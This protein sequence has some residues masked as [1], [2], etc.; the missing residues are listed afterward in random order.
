MD[1]KI[2][3]IYYL[4]YF[5]INKNAE[6]ID[7]DNRVIINNTHEAYELYDLWIDVI[8]KYESHENI[9][10][11]F[12]ELTNAK[13]WEDGHVRAGESIKSYTFHQMKARKDE[14]KNID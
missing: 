1:V 13:V 2:N 8:K 11:A 9:N 6:T 14:K 12:A 4:Y 5:V 3:K 10:Y 7:R